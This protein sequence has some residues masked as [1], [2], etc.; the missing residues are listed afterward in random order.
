MLGPGECRSASRDFYLRGERQYPHKPSLP[1]EE[2]AGGTDRRAPQ[3]TSGLPGFM[4]VAEK[5]GVD[6]RGNTLYKRSPDGEII[7]EEQE[8]RERIRINGKNHFATLK[9]KVPIV[10]NDL[11]EIARSLS[12]VPQAVPRAWVSEGSQRVISRIE[13]Y[14]YRCFSKLAVELGAYNVLAGANGSGKTTLLDIPVLLGDLVTERVCSAA[15]W[16]ASLRV[17][18]RERIP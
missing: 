11:P 6:R 8:E 14:R 2:D 15:F 17:A 12:R 16:K 10:D 1:Q 7:L 9:R 3:W 5:V 18:P 4:A 13:A